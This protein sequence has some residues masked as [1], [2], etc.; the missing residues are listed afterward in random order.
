MEEKN[1]IIILLYE[2]LNKKYK[3]EIVNII[4]IKYE[5]GVCFDRKAKNKNKGTKNQ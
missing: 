3:R 1:I 5:A 4:I 2:K